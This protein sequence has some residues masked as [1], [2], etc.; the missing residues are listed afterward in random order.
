LFALLVLAIS[1]HRWIYLKS[2]TTGIIFILFAFWYISNMFTG[3]GVTDA[4]YYQLYNTAQGTSLNDMYSKIEVGLIFCIIVLAILASS[5]YIKIK[6]KNLIPIKKTT[7]MWLLVLISIIPS[8]FITNIYYSAKDTFFNEGNA[9]AVKNEY[10]KI[11]GHL[12]K[13][14]NY[15]FIYAESLENTFQ[16][17]DGT[18]FTPGLSA[19]ANKYMQFTNIRQLLTRGMGWTMAG[20]VNTQCGIPLVLEQGNSGA[21]FTNFLGKADCVATWLGTQGYQ[22]EFIRGS[23]KE[24]AGGD[25]FLEQHGWQSQ[26]DKKYFAEHVLATPDDVSGWG[27]HDDL[28]LK[29][30]WDE[31]SRMSQQKQPFLLSLLTVNTH[32]PEG[33]FLKACENHVPKNDQYPILASV[34]CSDYLLTDFINRITHSP[35]F[36]N[37]IVVLVSDHLMMANSASPLLEKVSQERRN[38]FFIIKK[39]MKPTINNTEGTLLDVWPTVLDLSGSSVKELGFGT[40]LLDSQTGK[41]LKNYALGR[42]K[43]FLAYASQLWNYPSLKD[44]IK[45]TKNGIA[46]G[47]EEYTLPVFSAIEANG[48]LKAL[49]FEAFAMNA[50]RI[51]QKNNDLFYANLC[52]NININEDGICSYIIS[53][54]SIKQF[55]VNDLGVVTEK[56]I[57]TKPIFYQSDLLGLSSATYT[58]TSGA[59]INDRNV[60]I[61][62]GFNIIKL[63]STHEDNTSE[64]DTVLNFS[65]CDTTTIPDAEI[66]DFL[67]Q[68]SKP[69]IFVSNDSAVCGDPSP[70]V[71]LSNILNSPELSTLKFRQQVFGIYKSGHSELMK[72]TPDLPFDMFIDTK[73]YKLISLCNAFMDC[74]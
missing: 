31:F 68:Q 56:I 42:T 32:S 73:N 24:F 55:R 21:S 54:N 27:I 63:S 71:K 38:R 50:Q 43:D 34:A 51:I 70:I 3:Y 58:T 8:Q 48:Q 33:T 66:T 18:N 59:V 2:I 40:S 26:H 47:S 11:N 67:Q 74:H 35:W 39:D 28:L 49:W 60:N 44:G 45:Q 6:K 15:V 14:Y 29:H 1:S 52:R 37:T 30:A 20:L 19:L 25:K 23:Q 17:L 16:N 36:E 72:G 69:V 62:Y 12:D 53:R 57:N 4:V 9:A 13:K 7:F 22:T 46:I 64:T 61:G 65:T 10:K 41:F 5:V